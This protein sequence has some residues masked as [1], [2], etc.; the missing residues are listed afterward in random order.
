MSR[1]CTKKK[2]KSIKKMRYGK[3]KYEMKCK[4]GL[5]GLLSCS[6][7]IMWWFM[8]CFISYFITFEYLD[9]NKNKG[10]NDKIQIPQTVL[11]LHPHHLMYWIRW[12]YPIP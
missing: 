12:D 3:Y 7:F 2:H 4:W 6:T 5:S 9:F 10:K 11:F 1:Q 8:F